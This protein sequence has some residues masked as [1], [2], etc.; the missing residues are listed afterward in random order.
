MKR[1]DFQ[2]KVAQSFSDLRLEKDFYDVTLVT[3]DDVQISAHK[4]ILA[5]S[6]GFFKS[7]FRKNLHPHPLV[8]L[9]ETDSKSLGLALD[10]IYQGEAKMNQKH[11]DNFLKISRKLKIEDLMRLDQED[12][13]EQNEDEEMNDFVQSNDREDSRFI[14][15]INEE[16]LNIE[17]ETEECFEDK[18]KLLKQSIRDLFLVKNEEKK[19]TEKTSQEQSEEK[20]KR[21]SYRENNIYHCENCNFFTKVRAHILC[22]LESHVEG[23]KYE[24][25]FCAKTFQSSEGFRKHIGR[26]HSGQENVKARSALKLTERKIISA[27]PR[28]NAADKNVHEEEIFL[29]RGEVEDEPLIKKENNEDSSSDLL[30]YSLKEKRNILYKKNGRFQCFYCGYFSTN[31]HHALSH[32]EV[33]MEDLSYQCCGKKFKLTDNYTKHLRKSHPDIQCGAPFYS[34]LKISESLQIFLSKY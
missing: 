30:K 33:H 15:D 16:T 4:L 21:L 5:S 22:H 17:D 34:K 19:D 2:S 31:K 10:Y 23:I 12:Q 24:C 14:E 13:E 9:S 18:P 3:D 28:E 25:Q 20:P 26:L 7:I 11:V 6:S 32:A 8:Y 27:E 29:V 1:N